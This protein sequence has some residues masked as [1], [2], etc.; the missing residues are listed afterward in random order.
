V[1]STFLVAWRRLEKVTV[2]D[3][4]VAWRYGVAYRTLANQ[5]RSAA[6]AARL[7]ERTQ[8]ELPTSQPSRSSIWAIRSSRASSNQTRPPRHQLTSSDLETPSPMSVN[9]QV[10]YRHM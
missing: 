7:S 3:N 1:A 8:L 9:A 2:A 5:R 6:R 4:P 10:D